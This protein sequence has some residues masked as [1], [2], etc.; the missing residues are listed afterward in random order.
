[1]SRARYK[2]EEIDVK[3]P[4]C[5]MHSKVKTNNFFDTFYSCPNCKELIIV[6][7]LKD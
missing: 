3:C 6:Q 5:G 7:K 2:E 1:M 4:K